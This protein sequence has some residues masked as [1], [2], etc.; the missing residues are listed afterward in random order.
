MFHFLDE[1]REKD[2]IEKKKF[3]FSIAFLITAVIVALWIIFL[4]PGGDSGVD[5][6]DGP[7]TQFREF[8]ASL[9]GGIKDLF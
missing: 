3:A 8:F 6:L 2:Q 5:H 1:I 4:F 9:W 7:F